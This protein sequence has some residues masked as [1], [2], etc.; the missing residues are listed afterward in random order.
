MKAIICVLLLLIC[1]IGSATAAT[2]RYYGVGQLTCGRY[3][4][5]SGSEQAYFTSYVHGWLSAFEYKAATDG[6]RPDKINDRRFL[7][8]VEKECRADR[9]A[10]FMEVVATAQ[11]LYLATHAPGER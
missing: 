6:K 11:V 10:R 2:V 1:V 8:E 9:D 3:L 5:A 4:S 7:V